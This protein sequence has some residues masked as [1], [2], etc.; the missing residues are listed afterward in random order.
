MC[1]CVCVCLCVFKICYYVVQ[2]IYMCFI[3]A[4]LTASPASLSLKSNHSHTLS[5]GVT[6]EL[7]PE[8]HHWLGIGLSNRNFICGLVSF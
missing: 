6:L 3:R 5:A 4:V 7:H 1:M 8:Q 2:K